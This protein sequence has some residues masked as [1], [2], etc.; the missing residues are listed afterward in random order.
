MPAL[1]STIDYR[2]STFF[3]AVPPF[4]GPFP[5]RPRPESALHVT[6]FPDLLTN[7]LPAIQRKRLQ[8]PLHSLPRVLDL[9]RIHTQLRRDS[10][11]PRLAVANTSEYR[12]CLP[13]RP[14][15]F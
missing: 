5:V 13:I 1:H 2:H 3:G 11:P 12:Q 9:E 10:F 14:Q 7:F 15:I 4:H 8:H 6:S